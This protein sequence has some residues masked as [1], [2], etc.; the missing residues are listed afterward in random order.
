MQ[1]SRPT[2]VLVTGT[3]KA[4]VVTIAGLVVANTNAAAQTCLVHDAT[5]ATNL[6]M[7]IV[8]LPDTTV[9]IPSLRFDVG[10]HLVLSDA[11][12]TCTVLEA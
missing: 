6:V 5:G 7:T 10:L 9:V 3:Y 1:P 11:L 2:N 4:G 8:V 12:I